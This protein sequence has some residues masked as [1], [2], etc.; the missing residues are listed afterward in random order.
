[1]TDCI[2]LGAGM[3]GVGIALALQERGWSVLLVDRSDPGTET[4]YGNAGII[5][6]EAVSPYALPRAPLELLK[7]AFGA[8]N[9]V[10]WRLRDMPGQVGPLSRYWHNSEARRHRMASQLYAR[11]IRRAT[12]D[13][14]PLIKASG[15]EKLI[16]RTGLRELHRSVHSFEMSARDAERK[17]QEFGVGSVIEDSRTVS[18]A[19]PS[20]KAALTG[21]IHW[22]DPWSC[23][24]P[25][26]LVRSYVSLFVKRGGI[27]QHSDARSLRQ[28]G[29]GWQIDTMEG[30]HRARHVVLAL[31][32]WSP[33]VLRGFGYKVPLVIKRGYHQHF[34]GAG[35]KVPIVD[36]GNSTVATPMRAGLR[37]LTGAEL[38]PLDSAARHRQLNRS[39]KA[40]SELFDIGVPLES[41]PW[42][43]SRP[44]MPRMLPVVAE[45]PRHNGLWLNFGHGHQGFTLGPTTGR[46][47]AERMNGETKDIELH[48][49]LDLQH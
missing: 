30:P 14:A 12:D 44:C 6:T 11:M 1:M 41:I 33:E 47:L 39:I 26:A 40:I 37:I 42:F 27:F 43:G 18:A 17:K 48:R 46:I 22:T 16:R 21:A 19:E 38:T 35:P 4:S 9:Q 8:N 36:V 25:G 7:A 31:G 2:V 45:A 49:A 13:H 34:S 3:V 20:L 28:D 32:P 24:D 15:A 29:S 23:S 10:A 5:Q